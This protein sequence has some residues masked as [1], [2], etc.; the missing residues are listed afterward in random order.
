MDSKDQNLEL[1]LQEIEG[2]D[3]YWGPTFRCVS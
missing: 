1:F 3:N 2:V